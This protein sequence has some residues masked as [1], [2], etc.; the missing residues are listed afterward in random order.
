MFYFTSS[1]VFD[2][3]NAGGSF[4]F[5]MESESE[6]FTLFSMLVHCDEINK[7]NIKN[8][9]NANEKKYCQSFHH[10]HHHDDDHKKFIFS[11]EVFY[12]GLQTKRNV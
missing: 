10:H 9:I 4:S 12:I 7:K 1:Y 11:K 5:E 3:A 2:N 6:L 8:K